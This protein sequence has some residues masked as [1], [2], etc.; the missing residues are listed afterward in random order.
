MLPKPTIAPLQIE[1]TLTGVI[2]ANGGPGR[3]PSRPKEPQQGEQFSAR[4]LAVLAQAS[5]FLIRSLDAPCGTAARRELAAVLEGAR[6]RHRSLVAAARPL[7]LSDRAKHLLDS[8]NVGEPLVGS[9][10]RAGREALARG[11]R[12][13]A[14]ALIEGE[15]EACGRTRWLPTPVAHS[16]TSSARAS[17]VGG[18]SRPSA[19]AVLR[20]ITNSYLVGCCTGRSAGLAL[21]RTLST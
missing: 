21:F 17:S 20:L 5:G 14:R 13:K 15:K 9:R 18:T 3:A 4:L 8:A 11:D 1:Q 6:R 2:V 10:G 7:D 12:A 16:I 19:L